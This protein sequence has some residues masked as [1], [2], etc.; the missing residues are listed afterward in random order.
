MTLIF[1]F[2]AYT[3]IKIKRKRDG[4]LKSEKDYDKG[5]LFDTDENTKKEETIEDFDKTWDFQEVEN[6][7][8][9]ESDSDSE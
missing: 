1:A 7:D 4:K 6:I 2:S 5:A 3:L 9:D 8:E